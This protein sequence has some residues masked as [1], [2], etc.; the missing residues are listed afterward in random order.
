MSK[1]FSIKDLIDHKC[2]SINLHV[3]SKAKVNISSLP[4]QRDKRDIT[5]ER[6]EGSFVTTA[7]DVGRH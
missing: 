5:E 6:S 7:A 1:P 3:N 2:H 4:S